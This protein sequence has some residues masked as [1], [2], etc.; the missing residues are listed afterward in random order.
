MLFK[1][2]S[3]QPLFQPP[4]YWRNSHSLPWNCYCAITCDLGRPA[5]P[6][7]DRITKCDGERN[8]VGN[9]DINSL[10]HLP[11]LEDIRNCGSYRVS[12][13]Y[14]S[15]RENGGSWRLVGF[16]PLNLILSQSLTCQLNGWWERSFCVR[17]WKVASNSNRQ[18]SDTSRPAELF[19]H[20][21][22]HQVG[23]SFW[24]F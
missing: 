9:S 10:Q 7:D 12:S 23:W 14:P 20:G 19:A 8:R 18:K 17:L 2:H 21:I 11:T 3:F 4:F 6:E 24:E 22:P 1:N 16:C 13:F 5:Y 15:P